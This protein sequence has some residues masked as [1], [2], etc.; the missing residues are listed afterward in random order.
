MGNPKA[1]I[2]E[3]E[4]KNLGLVPRCIKEI[5]V[6]SENSERMC[7]ISCS[8]VQIYNEKVYDLLNPIHLNNGRLNNKKTDFQGLRMRL[9]NVNTD[10]NGHSKCNVYVGMAQVKASILKIYMS[11][12]V[13]LQENYKK[14]FK[15]GFRTKLWARIN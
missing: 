9:V 15:M 2:K 7:A 1:E 3:T 10:V 8:F 14:C 13:E 5:F 6:Q 11:I 12:N 4:A